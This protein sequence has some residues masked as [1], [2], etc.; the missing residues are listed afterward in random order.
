MKNLLTGVRFAPSPTGNF[1]I[2]NLRTAWI[3]HW[4]A[5]ALGQPWVVRFED[6]DTA[7][8]VTNA[9][10]RQLADMALLNL[11]PDK[12]IVQSEQ[13]K[14]HEM[15]F[16]QA[17]REN[18]VYPCF[19][20]RKDILEA[21]NTLASAP[22]GEQPIYNG[23]CRKAEAPVHYSNPSIAWRFKNIDESG[24][25]DFIIARTRPDGSEFVPS[26]HWACAIDDYDGSYA[27]L[28]RAWDLAP[29]VPQQRAIYEWVGRTETSKP[30]PA[31]F[32]TA[33]IIQDDGHRL[34]KRSK[35]AALREI[36]NTGLSANDIV[37]AFEQSFRKPF[38]EIKP[39]E[40]LGE[41]NR[42]LKLAALGLGKTR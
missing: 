9:Q 34:E 2:G 3:S 42:R 6:I 11:T 35:G 30:Y 37:N 38:L 41:A 25:Q 16:E 20:S 36:L 21:L 14:R 40:C 15:L 1:H 29:V 19:C 7:R 32:H 13:Y 4:W 24:A 28:V 23:K 8:V 18:A 5:R 39:G 26:Y 10:A 31:V 12:I 33:L 22:H 27:L 17:R